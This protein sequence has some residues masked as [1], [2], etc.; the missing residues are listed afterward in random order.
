MKYPILSISLNDQLPSPSYNPI[1]APSLPSIPHHPP[2]RN[3]PNHP[4][5][6][7]LKRPRPLNLAIQ[8]PHGHLREKRPQHLRR[9]VHARVQ[10]PNHGTKRHHGRL[11]QHPRVRDVRLD[12]Q[13]RPRIHARRPRRIRPQSRNFRRHVPKDLLRLTLH[14][15]K[16]RR[17]PS[18]ILRRALPRDIHE[19]KRLLLPPQRRKRLGRLDGIRLRNLHIVLL[20]DLGLAD[21][22]RPDA[23]ARTLELLQQLG[24]VLFKVL[25]QDDVDAR[26]AGVVGHGD[27]AAREDGDARDVLGL[28]H[29]VEDRG[30]DEAGCAGED[31]MHFECELRMS[32]VCEVKAVLPALSRSIASNAAVVR[33]RI[34]DFQRIVVRTQV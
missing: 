1:T 23:A 13:V 18:R 34:H 16:N 27:G 22:Q 8:P 17:E 25:V 10:V 5:P 9:R 14:P 26:V 28:E 33:L 30:A 21:A 32:Y 3:I 19:P 7:Q 2:N 4:P 11:E 12:R 20:A 31:E 15:R 24:V 29:G 6:S